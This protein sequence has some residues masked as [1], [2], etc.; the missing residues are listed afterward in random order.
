[1]NKITEE[2]IEDIVDN[3]VNTKIKDISVMLAE[4]CTYY[5][6]LANEC[7]KTK[8]NEVNLAVLTTGVVKCAEILKESLKELLCE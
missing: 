2:Q 5:I 7:P 1:M 8:G 6:N 3:A 4:S